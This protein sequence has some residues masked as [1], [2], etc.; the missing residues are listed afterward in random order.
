MKRKVSRIIFSILIAVLLNGCFLWNPNVHQVRISS[1]VSDGTLTNVKIADV[2]YG[3]I[4]TGAVTAY[5]EVPRNIALTVTY[6]TN[7]AEISTVTVHGYG[8]HL[9]SL[10]RRRKP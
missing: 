7:D 9:C 6:G 2:S 3:D 5:K 10:P 4:E 8:T 1:T